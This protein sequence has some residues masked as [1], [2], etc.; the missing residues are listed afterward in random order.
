MKNKLFYLNKIN[1]AKAL[2][3]GCIFIM[4]LFISG[5]KVEAV[6]QTVEV[7]SSTYYGNSKNPS[8][9]VINDLVYIQGTGISDMDG[10]TFIPCF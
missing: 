9:K 1:I 4:S 10:I 7:L 2:V 8:A 3:F 5:M 6:E